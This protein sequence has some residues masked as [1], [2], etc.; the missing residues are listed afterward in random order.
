MADG[1]VGKYQQQGS[2]NT[3]STHNTWETLNFPTTVRQDRIYA[4]PNDTDFDVNHTG[5]YLVIYTISAST[6]S[7]ANR[8]SNRSR[9]RVNT[10]VQESGY[11]GNYTRTVAENQVYITGHAILDLTQGDTI[12]VQWL[13]EGTAGDAGVPH[14]NRGQTTFTIVQLPNENHVAYGRYSDGTD[15]STFNGTTY[16]NAPFDTNEEETDTSVIERNPGGAGAHIIRLK[17]TG[18]YLVRY[19]IEMGGGGRTQR[20]FRCTLGGTAVSNSHSYMYLRSS[21]TNPQ[22]ATAIFLVD[23]TANDDLILQ[24]QRGSADIDSAVTRTINRSSIEVMELPS[25]AETVMAHDTTALQD[26]SVAARIEMNWAETE[27]QRDTASFTLPT[28]QEIEVEKNGDYLFFANGLIDKVS[29]SSTARMM[30]AIRFQID[31]LIQRFGSHGTFVRG[32]NASQGTRNGSFNMAILADGMS[33]DQRIK[34]TTYGDGSFGEIDRTQASQCG[35]DGLNIDTMLV[36][37]DGDFKVDAIISGQ[38]QSAN[39]NKVHRHWMPEMDGA[40]K[41]NRQF[42][43][44]AIIKRLGANG[45]CNF[46]KSGLELYCPLNGNLTDFSVNQHTIS[47]A[48]GAET[49]STTTIVNST[50]SFDH[51]SANSFQVDTWLT[52]G[53]MDWDANHTAIT[54][55]GWFRTDT[56][57]NSVDA[58]FAKRIGANTGAGWNLLWGADTDN[59]RWERSQGDIES[60]L[61]TVA[62]TGINTWFFIVATASGS[63]NRNQMELSIF[64]ATTGERQKIIGTAQATT[65]NP[66]NFLN[67]IVG[68]IDNSPTIQMFEGFSEQVMYFSR[69]ISDAEAWRLF[70]GGR[71]LSILQGGNECY[72]VDA[73][74]LEETHLDFTIDARLAGTAEFLVD[75][76]IVERPTK[77]FTVDA[78]ITTKSHATFNKVHKHFTPAQARIDTQLIYLVDAILVDQIDLDFTVDAVLVDRL[79]RDFTV[80]AF[81]LAEQTKDF[82]VDAIVVDRFTKTFTVD[83][84]LVGTDLNFTVDSILVD[85]FDADFTVDAWIVGTELDYLVDSILVDRFDRDYLV[86]ALLEFQGRTK[87]FTVD[88]ILVDR[89]DADFLVDAFLQDTFTKDFLVDAIIVGTKLTYLVDAFIEE[90]QTKDFTVDAIFPTTDLNFDVDAIIVDRFTKDSTVDAFLEETFTKVFDVDSILTTVQGLTFNKTHRRDTSYIFTIPTKTFQVDGSIIGP[91]DRDFKVDAILTFNKEFTADAILVGTVE[92]FLVDSILVDRFD[93][94]FLVDP[95]ISGTTEVTF[96]VDAILTTVPEEFIASDTHLQVTPA[97]LDRGAVANQF[98]VDAFIE[99]HGLTKTFLVDAQLEDIFIKEFDVDAFIEQLQTKTFLV[100]A[101]VG[102]GTALLRVDAILNRQTTYLVDAILTVVTEVPVFSDTHLQVPPSLL[103]SDTDFKQFLVDAYLEDTFDKDFD[104]DAI[105][106]DRF[107]ADYLVDAVVVDR[108]DADYLVDAYLEETFEKDFLVD[109]IFPTTKLTYLVDAVLVDRFDA[110]YL[111]DSIL[112]DRFGKT[113]LV[114]AILIDRKDADYLVDAFIEQQTDLDYLVDAFLQAE[115]TKDFTVDAFVGGATFLD[116]LVDAFLQDAFDADYLVD[117]I[118]VDRFDRDLEVDALL[119]DTFDADT[120]VDAILVDRF[121]ADFLVDAFLEDIFIKE[122]DVDALLEVEGRTKDFTVDSILTTV[123]EEFIASDNHLQVTPALLTSDTDFK[124]F[125]VDALLV[126]DSNFADFTVDALLVVEDRTKDFLVDAILIATFDS[127]FTVDAQLGGAINILVDAILG[128]QNNFSVD[129]LLLTGSI[130]VVFSDTHLQQIAQLQEGTEFEVFQVDAL[131]EVTIDKDFLVD[132]YLEEETIKEFDVDAILVVDKEKTFTVDAQLTGDKKANFLVDAVLSNPVPVD[133]I[134]DAIIRT[135]H[136]NLPRVH[137]FSKVHRRG[138]VFLSQPDKDFKV[139][140]FLLAEQPKDFL[141]DALLP[142][143]DVIKEF[144]V[145]ARIVLKQQVDI[146]VDALLEQTVPVD[147]LVDAIL[148]DR[149]DAT[150]LV[151]AV[152][153]T[154]PEVF[155]PSPVLLQSITHLVGESIDFLVDVLLQGQNQEDYL[156]DAFL[157]KALTKDFLVDAILIVRNEKTFLVDAFIEKEQTKDYLVDAILVV[158]KTKTFLVDAFFEEATPKDFLVDAI[159]ITGFDLDFLVDALIVGTEL[160]YDVDAVLVDRFLAEYDVD[161]IIV[162]RFNADYLVDAFLVAEQTRTFLVDAFLGKDLN[163]FVD[164]ILIKQTDKDYLVD[165]ILINRNQKDYLVDAYVQKLGFNQECDFK[166]QTDLVAYLKMN[167]DVLDSSGLGND[168]YWSNGTPAFV[169]DGIKDQGSDGDGTNGISLIN[170]AQFDRE[171]TQPFSIVIWFRSTQVGINR[172]FFQKKQNFAASNPGI[173][174]H[175]N[176]LN[177][178]VFRMD[179]GT[180]ATAIQA[181]ATAAFDGAWHQIIATFTGNSDRSGMTLW[182]DGV[183]HATASAQT[184][185]GSYL[186]NLEPTLGQ[187]GDLLNELDGDLDEFSFWN[188]V[189]TNKEIAKLWNSGLGLELDNTGK[190]CFDVDAILSAIIPKDFLVDAILI[191][192]FTSLDY[193]VDAIVTKE[194]RG[195]ISHKSR[196]K[197]TLGDMPSRVAQLPPPFDAGILTANLKSYYKFDEA[198]GNLIQQA[199]AVGSTVEVPDSDCVNTNVTQSITGILGN[200]YEYNSAGNQSIASSSNPTTGW[201]FLSGASPQTTSI[202]FWYKRSTGATVRE[203]IWSTADQVSA[204]DEGVGMEFQANGVLRYFQ[205]EGTTFSNDFTSTNDFIISDNQW[206]MITIRTLSAK[207]GPA[208]TA[209]IDNGVDEL[210]SITG[211]RFGNGN[212]F[213]RIGNDSGDIRPLT[214][215]QLDELAMWHPLFITDQDITDLWNGGAGRKVGADP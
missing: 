122:F 81:L 184:M 94:T 69:K 16:V 142:N 18:Q 73:F 59:V 13:T 52:K 21:A 168:G 172:V 131:L 113:F 139:D 157:V 135:I 188:R 91:V 179:N 173:S 121:D 204:S 53:K 133:F 30:V 12:D 146:M 147:F 35:F 45:D 203:L 99:V 136:S 42:K 88:S 32:Q 127:D 54:L 155:V 80:D 170:E 158:R 104:V 193:L 20:V 134:V 40:G 205:W 56:D 126:S 97:L 41:Q 63:T 151:D 71:G 140:A 47:V 208:C 34:V 125:T 200:G 70:N 202:N 76:I 212:N 190:N 201:D 108:F 174:L 171:H 209:R 185:S 159:L 100:D 141:V 180:A 191:P 138:I 130:E 44:D 23:A 89:F 22:I 66:Q 177:N 7:V 61:Q 128:R 206:H 156:V 15:A 194:G 74:I 101:L 167:G 163:F 160:P 132:A 207:G 11:A 153:T 83:S 96:D 72:L 112:V 189:L 106:V 198:S 67:P 111:V 3:P 154:V 86:D 116:Y 48:E 117:A 87:D 68:G 93:K 115:Q 118:V 37:K 187:R 51:A 79:D 149:F 213:L 114:D 143:E 60:T 181:N 17:N 49:Y 6:E 199:N 186:N 109:A 55:C 175:S 82:L 25:S 9:L 166:N 75:A 98:L 162:D 14:T 103:A 8:M 46:D 119:E 84:I 57:N 148:V 197:R 150:S 195:I 2:Q 144:D 196:I 178:I 38:P 4:H 161:A 214:N 27:I 183:V 62:G 1:N 65:G 105:L 24:G 19:S 123:P 43:V 107:D 169:T 211:F 64:N 78:I 58:L 39:F 31:D 215:C 50:S 102:I 28:D 26:V 124:Q 110:D 36:E 33:V 137:T 90:L 85:R 192:E 29:T 165:A 129:A 164:A 152:L 95:L 182:L 120:D 10:T 145:D 77:T 5:K 176:S 92:Q 210:F